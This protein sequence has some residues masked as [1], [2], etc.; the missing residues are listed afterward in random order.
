MKSETELSYYLGERS[1]RL[2]GS[3]YQK[4]LSLGLVTAL[5]CRV[6]GSSPFVH[7]P[8][9]PPGDHHKAV[10]PNQGNISSPY[11]LFKLA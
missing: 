1:R 4:Q 11:P 5:V 3:E 2:V 8:L 10:T 7:K 9:T 6:C